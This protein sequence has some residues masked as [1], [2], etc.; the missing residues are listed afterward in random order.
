MLSDGT[1]WR[2]LIDV[3]DMAR[4]IEWAISRRR[5]NAA[6]SFSRSTS[7]R[8]LELSGEGS[9]RRG[10]RG[11]A[12]TRS[13]STPTAPPDKRS[14]GSISAL[15]QAGARAS[16]ARNAGD[17]DRQLRDGLAAMG[18][19]DRNFRKSQLIRLKVLEAPHRRGPARRR[20]CV[21]AT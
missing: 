16:T 6:D 1:P 9:G 17:V 21:G 20:I 13:A 11:G 19:A 18:F 8:K 15:F 12:G 10:R 7:A 2:P 5:P 14:Y 3:R 4:A